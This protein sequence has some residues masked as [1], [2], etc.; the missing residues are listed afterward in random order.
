VLGPSYLDS[1]VLLR[2]SECPRFS[3]VALR[4]PDRASM[5]Q[6]CMGCL[7]AFPWLRG[8]ARVMHANRVTG[9]VVS[10]VSH[11]K[12]KVRATTAV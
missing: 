2:L 5:A 7:S 8:L 10:F 12:G 9:K 4:D 6:R 3:D 11:L 1:W